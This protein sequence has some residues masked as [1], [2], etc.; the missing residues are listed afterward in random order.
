LKVKFMKRVWLT[1]NNEADVRNLLGKDK[2]NEGALSLKTFRSRHSWKDI[3][4][5]RKEI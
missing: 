4:Q 2:I 5:K 1:P 3:R